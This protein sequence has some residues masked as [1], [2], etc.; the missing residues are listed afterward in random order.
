MTSTHPSNASFAHAPFAANPAVAGPAPTVAVAP[1]GAR[2]RLARLLTSCW[3]HPLNDAAAIDDLLGLV[4]PTWSLTTI[5]A[6]VVEAIREAPGVRTLVLEPNRLWPGHVAG[7]HVVVEVEVDGRRLR[8]TFSLSSPPRGDGRLH[9]TVKRREGGKVSHWWNDTAAVGDVI[10]LGTPSGEFVLPSPLPRRVVMVSAGSGITPVMAM[11]RELH[12]RDARCEVIFVHAA[13][14]RADLIFAREL[15]TLMHSCAGWELR[16]HLTSENERLDAAALSKLAVFA[17]DSPAYVCGPDAF[18]KD[19]RRA[20]SDAGADANLHFE[21]FG[22]PARVASFDMA[23]ET[24]HAARGGRSFVAAAGQSLLEA[25]EA[26]GLR[27]AHGCRMGVCHT[28]KCRK[29][30]G[31]VEDLRDGR[32][33]DE[34]GEMIQLCVST[35]RSAVTLEL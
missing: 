35:A 2:T 10:T 20:W 21:H 18:M 17:A 15:E 11:L 33:S 31:V 4:D 28:C 22:L 8:R 27:P 1:G 13:H 16:L 14:S 23:A 5:K 30:S 34:P 25:A 9:V 12:T 29:I 6:R 7:Q 19:V 24:V 32:L 26:A 3:L